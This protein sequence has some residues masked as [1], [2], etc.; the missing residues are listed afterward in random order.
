MLRFGFWLYGSTSEEFIEQFP[1]GFGRD[2]GGR[3]AYV[4]TRVTGVV[5]PWARVLGDELGSVFHCC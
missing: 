4:G 5:K 1:V 2:V 3:V